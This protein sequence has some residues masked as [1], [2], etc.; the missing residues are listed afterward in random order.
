MIGERLPHHDHEIVFIQ[1]LFQTVLSAV[2]KGDDATWDV[3]ARTLDVHLDLPPT[4]LFL[5][6]TVQVAPSNWHVQV[7]GAL[8]EMM[9]SDCSDSQSSTSNPWAALS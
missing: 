7:E 8:Q 1:S 2:T 3:C 5:A 6:S 9:M 4:G